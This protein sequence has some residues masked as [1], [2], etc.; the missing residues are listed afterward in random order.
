MQ[1]FPAE[2]AG[3]VGKDQSSQSALLQLVELA[4]QER[5]GEARRESEHDGDMGEPGPRPSNP[6]LEA[7][8][9]LNAP[10]P[11]Q[12]AAGAGVFWYQT[13]PPLSQP[14]LSQTLGGAASQSGAGGGTIASRPVDVSGCEGGSVFPPGLVLPSLTATTSKHQLQVALQESW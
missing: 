1:A 14:V 13:A 9:A 10:L 3:G 5:D 4:S 6:L 8:A 2:A 11:Q 7:G 12:D